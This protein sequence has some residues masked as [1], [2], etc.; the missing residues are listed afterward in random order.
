MGICT[1]AFVPRMIATGEPGQI[2]NTSSKDGGIAP[3]P[4]ASV[5]A[6]SKAA[7]SCFTE[8]LDHNLR[9]EA[10]ALRA[11]VFYPSGGL[12]DTG[13]YT[14]ARNRPAHLQRQGAGTGRTGMSFDELKALVA[15]KT[16]RE[17]A[18]A[19]LDA[20]GEFVADGVEQRRFIIAHDLE[21]S[22]ALLRRRADAVA[23]GR[24]PDEHELTA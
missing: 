24:T 23:Q 11:S 12:M 13:L 5:Y 22:A 19:D 4:T 21:D 16:G 3:V 8:S 20:L 7:V 9:S 18:V 2:I 10:T 17:P 15:A 14:A 6:A 1:S